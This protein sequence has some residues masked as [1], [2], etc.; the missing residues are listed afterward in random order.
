MAIKRIFIEVLI[1]FIEKIYNPE[2]SCFSDCHSF[3]SISKMKSIQL[4]LLLKAVSVVLSHWMCDLAG[5]S[6][7][8]NDVYE[9]C[10]THYMNDWVKKSSATV[11]QVD[12]WTICAMMCVRRGCFCL[13]FNGKSIHNNVFDSSYTLVGRRIEYC[14]FRLECTIVLVTFEIFQSFSFAK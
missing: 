13:L 6:C 1:N 2:E 7:D 10:S 11:H 9:M 5:I 12:H 14:I 8:G 4:L 3:S